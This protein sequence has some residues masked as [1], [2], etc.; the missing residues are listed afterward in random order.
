MSRTLGSMMGSTFLLL[1]RVRLDAP[2][3]R[4]EGLGPE[5]VEVVAQR[6]E[7][8]RVQRIHPPVAERLVYDQ[9]GV[10]QDAQMLRDRRPADGEPAREL[11]DRLRTVQQP[12]E[13]GTPGRVAN[14][15]HRGVLASNH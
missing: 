8:L 7:R 11:D 14:G 10:L 13:D 12:R 15:V 5:V 2:L 1:F 3:E 4:L 9:M 6:S